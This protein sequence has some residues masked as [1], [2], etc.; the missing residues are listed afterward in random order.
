VRWRAED[1]RP[2]VNESNKVTGLTQPSRIPGFIRD[3]HRALSNER[4]HEY[5]REQADTALQRLGYYAWNIALCESLYPAL[6]LCEVTL[7][8]SL[9]ETLRREF[10]VIAR[11][12]RVTCW[13][14]DGTRVLTQEHAV[15]VAAAKRKLIT[16]LKGSRV[17][18]TPGRLVA[19]MSFGFWTYLF[20]AAYGFISPGAPGLWPRLL[21]DVFPNLPDAQAVPRRRQDFADRLGE[22]LR[23][24]NRAFHHE[25]LW[26]DPHL[27][28]K[29]AMVV[30]TIEWMNPAV[31]RA[32]S[33][34]DRFGWVWQQSTARYLRR[35][36]RDVAKR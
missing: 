17:P 18:F 11:G 34:F 5:R 12:T 16:A 33:E 31:A 24:R 14:D 23:L 10:P 3:A 13:M 21:D 25:P 27:A 32:L 15:R 6:H 4:L 1:L 26:K 29:H 28:D 9:F 20:D 36:I 7:R 22:I 35:T 8:N 19:E 30:E 2:H